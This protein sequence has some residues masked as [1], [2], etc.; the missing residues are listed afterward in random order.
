MI[1]K[2]EQVCGTQGAQDVDDHLVHEGL[3]QRS[4]ILKW[5]DDTLAVQDVTVV[6]TSL[7]Y[8]WKQR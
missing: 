5:G 3:Y 7:V 2:R 1:Y 4:L 6:S 8:A